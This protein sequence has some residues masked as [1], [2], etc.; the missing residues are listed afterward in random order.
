MARG[1]AAAP[2]LGSHFWKMDSTSGETGDASS[3]PMGVQISLRASDL[4]SDVIAI[5]YA[6]E[7][8]FEQSCLYVSAINRH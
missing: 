2:C 8:G 5:S 4:E 7:K 6:Y 3:A 1:Y